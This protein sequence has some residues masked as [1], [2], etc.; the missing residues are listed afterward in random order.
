MPHHEVQF[1]KT[2]QGEKLSCTNSIFI[3]LQ[4]ARIST[5]LSFFCSPC[6]RCPP[7]RHQMFAWTP[8]NLLF[9]GVCHCGRLWRLWHQILNPSRENKS[10][11]LIVPCFH[12]RPCSLRRLLRPSSCRGILLA[13]SLT[14]ILWPRTL[15]LGGRTLI[16]TKN[17]TK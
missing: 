16:R 14:C 2:V 5:M 15:Y 8:A 4:I 10:V 11:T 13:E 17:T 1:G 7:P 3:R 9:L 12:T 6:V